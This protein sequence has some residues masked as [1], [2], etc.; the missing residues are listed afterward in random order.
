MLGTILKIFFSLVAIFILAIAGYAV[1]IATILGFITFP[2]MEDLPEL[3]PAIVDTS[4]R[5]RLVGIL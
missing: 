1:Y 3:Q 4:E 2:W 5:D